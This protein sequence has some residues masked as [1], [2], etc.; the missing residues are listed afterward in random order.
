MLSF[1]KSQ[2]VWN[3]ILPVLTSERCGNKR[4]HMLFDDPTSFL[5][6][7][8]WTL[9]QRALNTIY[10]IIQHAEYW[11]AVDTGWAQCWITVHTVTTHFSLP[12]QCPLPRILHNHP[13][14][15]SGYQVWGQTWSLFSLRIPMIMKLWWLNYKTVERLPHQWH[16]L[17]SKNIQYRGSAWISLGV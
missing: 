11:A 13:E 2:K 12:D 7:T 9:M 15:I 16:K 8:N 6:N 4:L 1:G 10:R 17:A 3:T 5:N 14:N